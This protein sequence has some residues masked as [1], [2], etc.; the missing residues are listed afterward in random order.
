MSGNVAVRER[1]DANN[2]GAKVAWVGRVLGVD[3]Q[4]TMGQQRA[5]EAAQEIAVGLGPLTMAFR[6][7]RL[8]W[9]TARTNARTTVAQLQARLREVLANERDFPALNVEISK[10]DSIMVGLDSRLEATLD[11]ALSGADPETMSKL[12]A[13]AQKIIGEYRAFVEQHP[14]L[15]K[16]DGNKFMPVTVF[17]TLSTELQ[18]LAKELA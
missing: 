3:L 1:S 8:S 15:R 16:I 12:K 2:V 11:E 14:F 9:G 5:Q 4:A 7:A 13:E 10:F 17:A 18:N 6:K